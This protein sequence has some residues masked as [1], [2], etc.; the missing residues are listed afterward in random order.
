MPQL[1]RA[2]IDVL[3]VAPIPDFDRASGSL[4]FYQ[5]LQMLARRYRVMLLGWVDAEDPRS[6]RYVKALADAGLAVQVVSHAGV[7]GGVSAILGRVRLCVLFEFF[8]S[9]ERVIGRV[10][11]LRPDLPV[12]IDSV[13]VHFLR[14]MRGV[15]YAMRPRR[16]ARKARRTMRRELGV[17]RRADLVLTVTECDRAQILQRLPK[18]RVSIVQNIHQV[19]EDVPGFNER[20]RNSL[21]FV[22]GF[23][24]P[25]NGDA[26]L[27]FCRDILPMVKRALGQVEVTIVGDRPPPEIRDLAGD[28]VVIAGW[29][30][31]M[32]PYLDSHCVAIAPLRVAE[33]MD[34]EDGKAALIADSPTAFAEAV[35]RLCTDG[36]LH[37]DLSQAG[38][39]QVRHRWDAAAV[40]A[41]LIGALESI[42]GLIPMPLRAPGRL[43][44]HARD[45]YVRSGLAQTV[46][47]ASAVTAWYVGRLRPRRR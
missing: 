26:V 28:G 18:A 40:E 14:E 4:R 2:A 15:P 6:P 38:R 23:A 20:R 44:A 42:R 30:P 34:L 24:H 29:V 37:R 32:T 25:P 33:G 45:A 39:S 10:R 16:A 8:T 31:E 13:D 12:V 1:E 7:V 36:E 46:E 27:F 17:Y 41:R 11:L 21:L 35:A 9:A 5:M 19:R 22:G 43:A 3:V 47:H